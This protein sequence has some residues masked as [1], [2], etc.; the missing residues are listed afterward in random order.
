VEVD[1]AGV[2]DVAGDGD[3]AGAGFAEMMG[4]LCRGLSVKVV[5]TVVRGAHRFVG[6]VGFI[7]RIGDFHEF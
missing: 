5:V 4:R 1:V 3:C 7:F 2:V 6:V